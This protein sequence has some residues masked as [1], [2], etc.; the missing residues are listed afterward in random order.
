MEIK[1]YCLGECFI[2]LLFLFR[3]RFKECDTLALFIRMKKSAALNWFFKLKLRQSVTTMT[4]VRRV[5]S[6]VVEVL[7]V[8]TISSCLNG[9]PTITV[10][11]AQHLQRLNESHCS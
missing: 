8:P 10:L 5:S 9:A 6:L 3:E 1:P 2:C 4:I 7:I 11:Q